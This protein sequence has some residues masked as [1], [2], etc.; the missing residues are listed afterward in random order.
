MMLWVVDVLMVGRLSVEALDAA[1]LGRLWVMGTLILAMGLML[2]LDPIATQAHGAG[3]RAALVRVGWNGLA[4]AILV[5]PVIAVLWLSTAPVLRLLGQRPEIAAAAGSFVYAQLPGIPFFLSYVVLR[6]WLQ[7]Q[8][9]LRPL[10]VITF[11]A[12]FVNIAGNWLL[13][14]GHWGF[15][16]LGV[17]GSGISTGITM[18]FLFA[19]TLFVIRA[20]D[21]E[22]REWRRPAWSAIFDRR[23][24]GRILRLGFPVGV[25]FGLEFWAF[26]LSTLW[27]GW[28]GTQALAGHTIA[29]N[30]ASLAFTLPMGISFATVTRVGNLLGAG[31]PR[32]AQRAA[33]AS[34]T[35]TLGAMGLIAA[36][37]I[38]G[39]QYLPGLYTADPVVLGLAAAVMPI[40]AAFQLFDG[41]Q[42][43]GGGVLRGQGRTVPAAVI[44]LLGYWTLG[45]PLGWWLTFRAGWGL[46]GIWWGLTLGLGVV[47]GSLMVWIA[48][49]G[50]GREPIAAGGAPRYHDQTPGAQP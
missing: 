42:A 5:S 11:A 30:L 18:I 24:V 35:L 47:A 4:A 26:G 3:D 21:R 28:L 9:I 33:W 16:R 43:I 40:A 20:L 49:R 19:S 31:D 23:A 15:P 10:V 45:L 12:N 44:N 25:Q 13:I 48:L 50:P 2:G 38:A 39:R 29:I 14:F 37:F 46:S 8:G 32:G 27:A 1:S 22:R 6:H 17:V 36:T 41:L 34:A 7:A